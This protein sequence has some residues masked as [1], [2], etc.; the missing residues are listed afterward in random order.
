MCS[1]DAPC[2]RFLTFF[3]HWIKILNVFQNK[4]NL[5]KS[6]ALNKIYKKGRKADKLQLIGPAFVFIYDKMKC[7]KLYTH[8]NDSEMQINSFPRRHDDTTTTCIHTHTD[9]TRTTVH[10][11]IK[12]FLSYLL[13]LFTHTKR[14][15]LFIFTE[16]M[17]RIW[18]M[19]LFDSV[20][21]GTQPKKVP[22]NNFV[23]RLILNAIMTTTTIVVVVCRKS[24]EMI[25][26]SLARSLSKWDHFS[27]QANF[28]LSATFEFMLV[29]EATC[30][31]H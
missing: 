14:T 28:I 31:T 6:K 10:T 9:N 24:N 26:H 12:S 1:I 29:S 2:A 20:W 23:V 5:I 30:D 18:E 27:Q 11:K 4:I 13:E 8:L 15:R 17:E 3:L 19:L 25:T 7:I 21:G 22:F 16:I